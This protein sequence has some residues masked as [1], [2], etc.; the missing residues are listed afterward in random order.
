MKQIQDIIQMVGRLSIS[1]KAEVVKMIISDI[2]NMAEWNKIQKKSPDSVY[3]AESSKWAKIA[4]RIQD[5]PVHLEG[6]SEQLKKDMREF[7]EKEKA[8]NTPC[9][10]Y[11]KD[12]K[13]LRKPDTGSF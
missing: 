13:T 8:I 4:K 2:Q 5:D 12:T 11:H 7:R 3:Q 9:A 10:T 6:Y 1:E